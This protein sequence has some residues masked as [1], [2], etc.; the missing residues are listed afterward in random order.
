MIHIMK[1]FS[2]AG[3]EQCG[4]LDGVGTDEQ[5]YT[6]RPG[7]ITMICYLYLLFQFITMISTMMTT[8]DQVG[9]L[10]YLYTW[11]PVYSC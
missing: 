6:W 9:T 10:N 5:P 1:M 7:M 8:I 2:Q 4:V 3:V 11:C